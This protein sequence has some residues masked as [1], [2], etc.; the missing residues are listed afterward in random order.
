M[1]VLL[2]TWGRIRQWGTIQKVGV[3][4]ELHYYAGTR[5]RLSPQEEPLSWTDSVYHNS[6]HTILITTHQK[7]KTSLP[8]GIAA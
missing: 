7:S 6:M 1:I 8:G 2:M 4:A 3:E 5:I